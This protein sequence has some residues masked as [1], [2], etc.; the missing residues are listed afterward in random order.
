MI[1][2]QHTRAFIAPLSSGPWLDDAG[3]TYGGIGILTVSILCLVGTV[4]WWWLAP[5][6]TTSVLLGVL[7]CVGVGGLLVGLIQLPL[8]LLQRRRAQTC[9]ACLRRMARGAPTCPHCD[10]QPLEEV[11]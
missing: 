4:L 6:A 2:S 11:V 8:S 1:W 5:Q 3:P 10:F 7:P 9:P